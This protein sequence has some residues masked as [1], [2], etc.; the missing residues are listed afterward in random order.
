MS[1]SRSF[2]PR[3]VRPSRTIPKILNAKNPT[4][5]TKTAE[6][7]GGENERRHKPSKAE[8]TGPANALQKK[9]LDGDRLLEIT[10]KADQETAA[11]ERTIRQR[12]QG[13]LQTKTDML[14]RREV[15]MAQ[16]CHKQYKLEQELAFQKLDA[17]FQARQHLALPEW[18]AEESPYIGR[19]SYKPN[20]H[21]TEG[22]E[23]GG[24]R[25]I[26]VNQ[27]G[28]RTPDISSSN[29]VNGCEDGQQESIPLPCCF[30]QNDRCQCCRNV[31]Q[32]WNRGTC[33]QRGGWNEQ[34]GMKQ[35]S[36]YPKNMME[37]MLGHMIRENET[38]KDLQPH[39][40]C[41]GQFTADEQ[42]KQ[43]IGTLIVGKQQEGPGFGIVS[44][45]QVDWNLPKKQ[46]DQVTEEREQ[47]YLSRSWLIQER[48]Q[49]EYQ[50]KQLMDQRDKVTEEK[51]QLDHHRDQLKNHMELLV[52]QMNGIAQERN[53]LGHKRDQLKNEIDQ[54][55]QQNDKAKKEREMLFRIEGNELKHRIEGQDEDRTHRAVN[56]A[57]PEHLNMM[58]FGQERRVLETALEELLVATALGE[59]NERLLQQM[60]ILQMELTEVHQRLDAVQGMAE[61]KVDP[62]Q[63]FLILRQIQKELRSSI[64]EEHG[65][66]QIFEEEEDKYFTKSPTGDLTPSMAELQQVA[67]G[68]VSVAQLG[69]NMAMAQARYAEQQRYNAEH[70]LSRCLQ[71]MHTL[72]ERA[73][74]AEDMVEHLEG[75]VQRLLEEVKEMQGSDDSPQTQNVQLKKTKM[76]DRDEAQPSGLLPM[77]PDSSASNLVIVQDAVLQNQPSDSAS[78]HEEDLTYEA[79]HPSDKREHGEA[80]SGDFIGVEKQDEDYAQE[81]QDCQRPWHSTMCQHNSPRKGR[82]EGSASA[83]TNP[84]SQGHVLFLLKKLHQELDFSKTQE[85]EENQGEVRRQSDS[86][87]S[88]FKMD[89]NVELECLEVTLCRRRAELRRCNRLLARARND[90]EETRGTVNFYSHLERKQ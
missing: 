56:V 45:T 77:R 87:A 2:I 5:R 69:H 54:L 21:A 38:I 1:E 74:D 42:L 64:T 89:I 41:D 88:R 31:F 62:A 33:M 22:Y 76:V 66:G 47:L 23:K 49:L 82:H 63:V 60:A 81:E 32:K 17:K 37:V 35:S 13:E 24:H 20:A 11:K 50:V 30:Q 14:Q 16:I 19:A 71:E 55:V 9:T 59:E 90:L 48:D 78:L 40:T 84:D 26:V 51:D 61:S 12:L 39:L 6:T 83:F 3:F 85:Q 53:H 44:P 72:Q 29:R 73:N 18:L 43:E 58:E 34:G 65:G 27:G 80:C 86:E 52:N 46:M 15:E 10:R 25:Q 28:G 70:R 4:C 75:E 8:V 79:K 68:V 7:I 36:E 67:R 57:R